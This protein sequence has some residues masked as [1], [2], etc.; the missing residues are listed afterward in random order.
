MTL[1]HIRTIKD[2]LIG[3]GLSEKI[4]NNETAV[5]TSEQNLSKWERKLSFG[6]SLNKTSLSLF[7]ISLFPISDLA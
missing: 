1:I 2:I 5:S 3:V 6:A 4:T 7:K